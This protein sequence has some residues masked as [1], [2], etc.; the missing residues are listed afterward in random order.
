M[1]FAVAFLCFFQASLCE[2]ADGEVKFGTGITK[3]WE[4]EN[5]G[6]EFDTNLIACRIYSPEPFGVMSVTFSIYYQAPNEKNE[7]ILLRVNE[8]VNPEW[9]IMAFPE[10]P[11]P[12]TGKYTFG[13]SKSTGEMIANGSVTIKEKTVE[14]KMPEKPK[15]EGTTLEALFNKF[16]PKN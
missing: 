1:L 14:E 10:L 8:E 15:A 9:N 13:L 7:K 5:E 11:L 6:T 4:I 3:D 16:K 12:F 2:A